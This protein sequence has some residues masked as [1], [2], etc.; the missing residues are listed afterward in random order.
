MGDELRSKTLDIGGR[1]VEV[2]LTPAAFGLAHARGIPVAIDEQMQKSD[3]ALAMHL[4]WI[5]AQPELPKDADKEEVMQAVATR[6]DQDALCAWIIGQYMDATDALKKSFAPRHQEQI[7]AQ[8][9][10][11]MKQVLSRFGLADMTTTT[12]SPNTSD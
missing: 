7:A 12:S 2:R 3:F 4:L 5:A 11:M 6:D 1:E 10:E 9:S 8:K